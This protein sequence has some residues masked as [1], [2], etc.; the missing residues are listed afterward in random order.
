MLQGTDKAS[1]RLYKTL[2]ISVYKICE[3]GGGTGY[4]YF[5]GFDKARAC[6]EEWQEDEPYSTVLLDYECTED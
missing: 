1:Y 4:I 2:N 6:Q 3:G 5:L